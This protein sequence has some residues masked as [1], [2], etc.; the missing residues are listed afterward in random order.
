MG[1]LFEDLKTLGLK[2]TRFGVVYLEIQVNVR[3]EL[4]LFILLF[5]SLIVY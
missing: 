1:R 4:K 3:V 2:I 5:K